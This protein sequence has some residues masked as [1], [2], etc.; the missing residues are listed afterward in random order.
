MSRY[1]VAKLPKV[2]VIEVEGKPYKWAPTGTHALAIARIDKLT[3]YTVVEWEYNT[4]YS[5][6]SLIAR[7]INTEAINDG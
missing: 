7:H 6:P 4:D 1:E 3:Q 5:E 2:F